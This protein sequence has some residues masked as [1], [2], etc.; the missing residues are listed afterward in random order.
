[1]LGGNGVIQC[2]LQLEK[3]LMT[4]QLGRILK[5]MTHDAFQMKQIMIMKLSFTIQRMHHK[6]MVV[7]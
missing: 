1:M 2:K 7:F 3:E 4:E 5:W 6:I